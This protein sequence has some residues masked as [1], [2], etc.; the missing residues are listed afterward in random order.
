MRQPSSPLCLC[1][2]AE[3]K[4]GIEGRGARLFLSPLPWVPSPPFLS[5]SSTAEH[6]EG[7]CSTATS[8]GSFQKVNSNLLASGS[9]FLTTFQGQAATDQAEHFLRNSRKKNAGRR[10]ALNN[11]FQ[12][13]KKRILCN[14]EAKGVNLSQLV[15]SHEFWSK[16]DQCQ[17]PIGSMR[18][19]ALWGPGFLASSS[20][21]P[22]QGQALV[23]HGMDYRSRSLGSH[24]AAQQEWWHPRTQHTPLVPAVSLHPS[25]ASKKPNEV[26][27]CGSV[28]R[29]K[30]KFAVNNI[31]KRNSF[32]SIYT[33]L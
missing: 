24:L 3:Q 31:F 27:V 9:S 18:S 23:S 22:R 11:T 19:R 8:T 16:P 13:P 15:G 7:S 33:S 2:Q 26:Q 1:M 21:Q 32:A 5:L 14:P 4:V 29:D 12:I 10:R 30:L 17:Q 25:T 6:Q 28:S 20:P